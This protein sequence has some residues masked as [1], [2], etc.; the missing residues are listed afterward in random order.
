MSSHRHGF[1][2]LWSNFGPYGDQSVHYHPCFGDDCDR[3]LIAPGR[4]CGGPRQEHEAI[5]L[6]EDGPPQ[7]APVPCRASR[8]LGCPDT[9]AVLVC[10]QPSPHPGLNHYDAM[11]HLWWERYFRMADA[12]SARHRSP[13]CKHYG[14]TYLWDGWWPQMV[15]KAR[16]A[17]DGAS[18]TTSSQQRSLSDGR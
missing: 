9:P 15:E 18:G 7:P 5:W 12:R 13:N 17:Q 4:D 14:G 3:V 10:H 11:E 2:A 8:R 1:I 6:T 16:A